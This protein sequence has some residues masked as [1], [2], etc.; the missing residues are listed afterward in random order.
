MNVMNDAK[1]RAL[2]AITREALGM[3]EQSC[4]D[5]SGKPAEQASACCPPQQSAAPAQQQTGCC[6][7]TAETMPD[8]ANISAKCCTP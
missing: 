7:A 5:T 8:S 2:V 3:P 6:A 4:C 1:R